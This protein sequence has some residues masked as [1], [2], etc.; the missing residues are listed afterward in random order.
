MNTTEI[1]WTVQPNQPILLLD[2]A[3][4][5]N[6]QNKQSSSKRRIEMEEIKNKK[7]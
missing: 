1:N 2:I 3:A 5:T 4:Q 7:K 6:K